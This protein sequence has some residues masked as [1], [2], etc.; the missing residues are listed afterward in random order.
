MTQ[1]LRRIC[2]VGVR[3]VGKSTL[4]RSVIDDLPHIDYIVGSS[5][6]RE[7]AGADFA[8]FDQ[9]PESVKHAYRVAAIAW[10]ERRQQT[11]GRHILCDGHTAL[12]NEATGQVGEV[13]TAAD[14]AFFKE[15][16]L[17]EAPA[18]VVLERRR[19]DQTKRRSFVPEIIEQ[20]LRAERES[21]ARVA[22]EEGMA[23]HL[24]PEGDEA[25]LRDALTA[26]LS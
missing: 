13:F 19:A 26:I 3:G 25:C 8:R 20:E 2:L 1:M 21:C 15:L 22:K 7:L 23:L 4:V 6:L 14:R 17:M 18:A 5:V 11:C 9:L 24:M 16:I 12:L 10:M